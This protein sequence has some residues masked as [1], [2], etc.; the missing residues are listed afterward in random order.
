MKYRR[1]PIIV[2]AEEYR[3]GLEDG[4]APADKFEPVKEEE[5]VG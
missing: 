2:E 1:K 4:F 3:P 5:E